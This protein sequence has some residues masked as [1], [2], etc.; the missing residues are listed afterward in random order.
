MLYILC[1]CTYYICIYICLYIFIFTYI[2]IYICIYI[3]IYIVE[4]QGETG[5]KCLT[6]RNRHQ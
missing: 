6:E 1:I 5:E 2:Y 4:E 3:Y